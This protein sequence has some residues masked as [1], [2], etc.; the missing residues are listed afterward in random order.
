VAVRIFHVNFTTNKPTSR[1][2]WHVL[3]CL[4]GNEAVVELVSV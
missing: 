2:K 4:I 3:V 1:R